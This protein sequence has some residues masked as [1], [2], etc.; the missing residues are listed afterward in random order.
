[1]KKAWK[2]ICIAVIAV[3]IAVLIINNNT[4]AS[5]VTINTSSTKVEVNK[6]FDITIK[7]ENNG[8]GFSTVDGKLTYSSAAFK[9]KGYSMHIDGT[10]SANKIINGDVPGQVGILTYLENGQSSENLMNRITLTLTF[11]AIAETSGEEFL[12]ID[13]LQIDETDTAT[14]QTGVTV[15]K[16]NNPPKIDQAS[17]VKLNV[18]D[19]IQLTANQTIRAWESSDINVATVDINGLVTGISKGTATL[20]AI[21]DTG[22]STI[23]VI[24]EERPAVPPVID[25]ASPIKMKVGEIICVSANQKITSWQ[26][27]DMSIA[28]V[29][30]YGFVMAIKKGTATLTATSSSGSATVEVIV[31]EKP[32]DESAPK[33]EIDKTSIEID[34][35]AQISDVSG[36]KIVSWTSDNQSVAVVDGNGK[37][38]GK[39]VGTATITATA[40]NGKAATIMVAVTAKPVVE[41]PVVEP[42]VV[43]IIPE[44]TL[45]ETNISVKLGDTTKKIIAYVNN[46]DCTSKVTWSSSDVNKLIIGQGNIIP[47]SLGT[48]TVTAKYEVNGQ[49]LTKDATVT[50]VDG[51]NPI[52]NPT[53]DRTLTVG[54]SEQVKADR[55]VTWQSSDTNIVTVDA[56]GKITAKK[57]G[58]ATITAT[59]ANGKSVSFKVTVKAKASNNNNVG[60]TNNTNNESVTPGNTSSSVNTTHPATGESTLEIFVILGV[61]TLIV[62]T[63]IF[64]RKSK[65]K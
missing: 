25:Q 17:P 3:L 7:I 20:K 24:V 22:S 53:G 43:V 63:I 29:D 10:D 48:V 46:E 12:T 15:I 8:K 31:E 54:Q 33:L 21:S 58:T 30:K 28:K 13:S 52:V 5:E 36:K 14:C 65:L 56:D 37:V 42:P 60:Q 51:D 9:Y 32:V 35:T 19:N 11:T 41:P 55:N 26:S 38:T 27:S 4:S 64:R 45:S 18:L 2:L 47:I 1:M 50:I 16:Q 57:V 49:T 40:E 34:Q 59:D 23:E 6:D 44:L 39:G 62:A 61:I